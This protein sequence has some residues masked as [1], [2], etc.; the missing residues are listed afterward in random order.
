MSYQLTKRRVMDIYGKENIVE[1]G[2]CEL[3]TLLGRERRECYTA[4]TYGWN[5]DVYDFGDIAICTGYRPFGGIKADHAVCAK[6]ENLARDL[7]N[8]YYL[9]GVHGYVT[10]DAF[11]ALI[12]QF[13]EEVTHA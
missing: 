1:V 9:T 2:Y 10:R 8:S 3:Q 11:R 12:D 4:G 13:I 6:Y 5:A 7:Y